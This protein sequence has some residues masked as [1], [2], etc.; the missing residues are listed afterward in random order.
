MCRPVHCRA[1]CASVYDWGR[2]AA[3]HGRQDEKRQAMK[4]SCK[5]CGRV[6]PMG[7]V[8]PARPGRKAQSTAQ[9]S[10]RNSYRWQKVRAEVYQ[11]D[12]GLCRWCLVNGKICTSRLQ[13]HHIIPLEESTATAYD[14]NWIITLCSDGQDSCHARAERG[15]IS[16]TALHKL[17][18]EHV[19]LP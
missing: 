15:K 17:A 14:E 4:A 1:V 8:C 3:G 9:A 7:Y 10:V 12:R 16:R 11:R 19:R 18:V 2:A 6:H 5:W 13:A